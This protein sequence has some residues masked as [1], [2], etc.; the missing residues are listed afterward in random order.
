MYGNARHDV[1]DSDSTLMMDD[2]SQL[3]EV[4]I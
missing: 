2:V 3:N 1:G 4:Q